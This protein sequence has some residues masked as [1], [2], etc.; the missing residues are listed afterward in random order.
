MARV[1]ALGDVGQVAQSL[2]DLVPTVHGQGR[3]LLCAPLVL[4]HMG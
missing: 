1:L 2:A 4:G 3:K